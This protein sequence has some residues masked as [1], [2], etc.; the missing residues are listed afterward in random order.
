M[1][2]LNSAVGDQKISKASS[3]KEFLTK[4]WVD[5][6][7]AVMAC[8]PVVYPVVRYYHNLDFSISTVTWILDIIIILSTMLFRRTA[9]RVT[10]N[11]WLWLLTCVATY[12]FLMIGFVEQN[13]R[14]LAPLWITDTLVILSTVIELWGRFSLGRNIGFVP[15]QR[16]VVTRGAYRYMRH[17]I[18]TGLFVWIFGYWLSGYSPRN[19]LL[20]ALGIFWF[21]V[22]SLVEE[23]F[24]RKD[25]GYAAYM[26]RVPWRWIPRIV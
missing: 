10:R 20:Y 14:P 16:E 9:V 11:P 12:W 19:T 22:K 23:N 15:A 1:G 13:G 5:K 7:L 24:L 2:A 21:C 25:P 8:I 17:P 18:Y 3:K 4:P 6:V 26:E